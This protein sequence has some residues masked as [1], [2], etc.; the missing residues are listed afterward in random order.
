MIVIITGATASGKD[1]ICEQIKDRG[2]ADIPVSYTTRPMRTNEIEG[3]EYHFVDDYEFSNMTINDRFIEIRGYKIEDGSIWH[4]GLAKS[5]IGDISKNNYIVILD[6]EGTKKL[7]SYLLL[8]Y[9]LSLIKTVYIDCGVTTRIKRYLSRARSEGEAY[10]MCRRILSD[11]K[12]I[13]AFKGE[14][15]YVLQNNTWSD[16]ENNI[17]FIEKI[18]KKG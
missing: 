16:L 8:H 15:E 4:Y 9:P 5:S 13:E 12:N 7:M 18:F 6:Y 1:T 3:K 14:Y 17:G 2:I 10:E 11:K